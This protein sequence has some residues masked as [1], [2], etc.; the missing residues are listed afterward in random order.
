MTGGVRPM[1]SP[2]TLSCTEV[3]SI[4][5]RKGSRMKEEITDLL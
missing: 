2:W 5:E 1:R 4:G 3:D